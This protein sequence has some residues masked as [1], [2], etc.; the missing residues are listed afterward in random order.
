MPK[1]LQREIL[2]EFTLS[3]L[4]FYFDCTSP[5]RMEPEDLDS[6]EDIVIT[7]HKE[8]NFS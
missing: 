3:G 1:K 8:N 6:V 2:G 5:T 7:M 4:L